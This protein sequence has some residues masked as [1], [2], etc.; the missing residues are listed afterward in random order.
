MLGNGWAREAEVLKGN[1]SFPEATRRALIRKS[2]SKTSGS[3]DS[4]KA[5]MRNLDEGRGDTLTLL[6]GLLVLCLHVNAPFSALCRDLLQL[7]L[8][9]F[10]TSLSG[11]V[12]KAS[13]G[14][15]LGHLALALGGH[16]PA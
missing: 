6:P 2:P 7:C 5:V 1:R 16:T 12:P 11:L 15:L 14:F 13:P 8:L 9:S 3:L 4:L 10:C